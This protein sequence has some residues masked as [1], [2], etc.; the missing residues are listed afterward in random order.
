MHA[1]LEQHI[2]RAV[3]Q[4]RYIWGQTHIASLSI[5]LLETWGWIKSDAG[6]FESNLIDALER[7][8]QS[9]L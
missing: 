8:I 3:Y 5:P 4:R 7:S 9:M 2:K 6:L 1:A